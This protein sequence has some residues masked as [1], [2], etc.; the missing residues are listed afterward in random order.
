MKLA[1]GVK[2]DNFGE[3]SLTN[4]YSSIT[5]MDEK[6]A[7]VS[8]LTPGKNSNGLYELSFLRGVAPRT[9]R[10]TITPSEISPYSPNHLVG[11]GWKV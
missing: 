7:H 3:I 1:A 2:P 8:I 9:Y 5:G 11:L 10:L 6:L 4:L